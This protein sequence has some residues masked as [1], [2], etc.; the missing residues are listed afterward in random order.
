MILIITFLFNISKVKVACENIIYHESC[1]WKGDIDVGECTAGNTPD[2]N[3]FCL[4]DDLQLIV[5]S[6][7]AAETLMK[8]VVSNVTEKN[9]VSSAP[10]SM[11]PAVVESARLQKLQSGNRPNIF[12][13]MHSDIDLNLVD[14]RPI[15][16]GCAK[17]THGI[18]IKPIFQFQGIRIQNTAAF[19]DALFAR[20]TGKRADF[21]GKVSF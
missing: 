12:A 11:V 7:K 17:I 1:K 3:D 6:S 18:K 10:R 15:P 2:I 5:M 21:L 20:K 9:G 19:D 13:Q 4:E 8:D 14:N 16:K